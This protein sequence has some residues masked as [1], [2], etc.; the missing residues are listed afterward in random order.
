MEYRY[1]KRIRLAN[2]DYSTNGI[3]FI[4]ICTKNR[5]NLFWQ[6]PPVGATSGRPTIGSPLSDSNNIG[7]EHLTELGKEAEESVLMIPA[8]YRGN[9]NVGDYVIMPNHIH[10]ILVINR[11]GPAADENP[12]TISCVIKQYKGVVSKLAGCS[13]W[14]KSFYEH[15]IR[16]EDEYIRIVQYIEENPENWEQD[17]LY[18][19]N[20][21]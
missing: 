11:Q 15:I 3:Y 4:T 13:I 14:Q 6:H 1:R 18:E 8:A 2:Y 16:S 20:F 19:T 9:V 5:E 21:K 12:P 10:L 7:S 17:S